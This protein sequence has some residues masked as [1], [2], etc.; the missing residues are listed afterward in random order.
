MLS[1]ETTGSGRGGDMMRK[2]GLIFSHGT[3]LTHWVESGLFDREVA[4]L[5]KLGDR[6]GEIEALTYDIPGSTLD[7][8]R[9]RIAPLGVREN[10]HRL[11]Y[12]LYGFTA[13][14]VS[15]NHFKD[16][17]VIRTTQLSG[18]WMGAIAKWRFG[19]P[20]VLRCGYVRSRFYDLGGH[21]RWRVNLARRL[22]RF[23]VRAADHVFTATDAD[24]AYL[25]DLAG[26]EGARFTIL[27]N[28]IDTGRFSVGDSA[29]PWHGEILFVGR[30]HKQKN[31]PALIDAVNGLDDVHLTIVGEGDQKTDLVQR[32]APSRVRFVGAVGNDEIPGLL[33]NCDVF[34][35]PSFY[36]GN[37]KSLLEAMSC[38]CAV[39]GARSPGISNLID[40]G[41]TGVL[42]ETDA[43]A[44]RH[45][46]VRYRD[47]AELRRRCREGARRFIFDN[48]D[49]DMIVAW[50]AGV[51]E[52]LLTGAHPQ[53]G[54]ESA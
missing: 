38:G 27:P 20:F 43:N 28:P 53:T 8:H 1:P 47:D 7:A 14:L 50:E 24:A 42:C 48:Y 19:T 5:R 34:A 12:R 23:V 44:I 46:F 18:A 54:K 49:L 37:P 40:D 9:D 15:P 29:K 35:L 11:D 52:T 36:E 6:I 30:L 2:L 25:Q 26:V 39:L 13:P 31:L 16:L 33:Q 3:R 21:P 10:V 17:D 51:I 32:A 41:E 4:Y 22:E 45:G